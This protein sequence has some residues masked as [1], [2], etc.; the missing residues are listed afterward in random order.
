MRRWCLTPLH[1]RLPRRRQ[2]LT[3][4]E[5]LAATLL[6]TLLIVAV[7]GVLTS[8]TRGQKALLNDGV[9]DAW[10]RR[11]TTQLEW[12]LENSRS[13]K[14]VPE[15]ILL[16]GYAGRDSQT[17][18]PL[19]C[20]S[21]IAYLV[22]QEKGATH[23]VRQET[24]PESLSLHNTWTELVCADVERIELGRAGRGNGNQSS[25]ISKATGK[26]IPNGPIPDQLRV[27]L[28]KKGN[29][30]PIYSNDFALR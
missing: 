15:G 28:Y 24:H 2:A 1:R 9:P 7:L 13:L 12:D 8:V 22:R 25:N 14:L 10:Q 6:A 18:A 20:P 4:V 29:A 30:S 11:L 3:L 16:E 19:H 26:S 5:I 23:L 17:G 27:A 21:V